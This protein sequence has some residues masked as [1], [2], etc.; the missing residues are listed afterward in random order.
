MRSS[1]RDLMESAYRRFF[2]FRVHLSRA[3]LTELRDAN[4]RMNAH[5]EADM[6][7]NY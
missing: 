5:N 4:A 6:F 1:Y 3:L 7:Q 2:D